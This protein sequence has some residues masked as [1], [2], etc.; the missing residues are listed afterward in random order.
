MTIGA[1]ERR[2]DLRVARGKLERKMK[3]T[4]ARTGFKKCKKNIGSR[5]ISK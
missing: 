2:R 5:S 1:I 3:A 4:A